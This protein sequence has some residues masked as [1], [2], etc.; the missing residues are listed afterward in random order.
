MIN[1]FADVPIPRDTGDFRLLDRRV[2]DELN[3]FKETHG[4]LRGL[5]ALVGFEQTA[6]EFDRP[7]RH[8]GKG[9]YNRFS[10]LAAH[11]LQRPRRVLVG[12]AQ[13]EH[14]RSASWPP[15]WRS[16]PASPTSSSSSAASTSRSATRPSSTLVLLHR[17]ASADLP[18]HP[19]PVRRSDLR[20]GQAA[21]AL[22]RL[23]SPPGFAGARPRSRSARTRSRRA[24]SG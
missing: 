13:P 24:V 3:R 9:N 10:R 6:V 2:V 23:A 4:F 17:R 21:P 19:R 1:R 14:R 8:S 15:R 22:H 11:R 7:A 16:S 5:V 12:A 20:G 18:R